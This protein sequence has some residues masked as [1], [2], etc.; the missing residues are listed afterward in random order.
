[1]GTVPDPQLW[2]VK[3]LGVFRRNP[4]DGLAVEAVRQKGTM[5]GVLFQ[6]GDRHQYD[7]LVFEIFLY[8]GITQV[9][10][11]PCREVKRHVLYLLFDYKV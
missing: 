10:H 9:P 8:V 4:G 1:M 5:V 2:C 6:A 11:I 7:I 3:Y